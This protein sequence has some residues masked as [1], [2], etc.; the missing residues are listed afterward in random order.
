MESIYFGTSGGKKMKTEQ[1]VLRAPKEL[2]PKL[3]VMAE[4]RGISINQLI[5]EATE[6]Y[7]GLDSH[8]FNALKNYYSNLDKPVPAILLRLAAIILMKREAEKAIFGGP[9]LLVEAADDGLTIEQFAQN[10]YNNAFNQYKNEAIEQG[11]EPYVS[12]RI[13]ANEEAKE[14]R[15]KAKEIE[16]KYNLKKPEAYW[17]NEEPKN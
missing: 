2:R 15:A 4:R 3:K 13:K 14:A 8:F 7:T 5:I 11:V 1:I 12:E 16:K 17:E 10:Q 9:Q 6:F